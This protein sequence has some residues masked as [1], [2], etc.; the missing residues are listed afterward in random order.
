MKTN[1]DKTTPIFKL[2]VEEFLSILRKEEKPQT[3]EKKIPEIFDIK[4]IRE[5]TG[6]SIATIYAKTS[7]KEIPHFRRD[8]RLFFRRD[9]I[10]DWLTA[11]PVKTVDEHCRALDGKLT[12]RSR[13]D[14][15]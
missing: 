11:N 4:T 3:I 15:L 12:K 14:A 1:F 6:Y 7:K 5:I 2:T 9:E 8:G 10:M 13:R